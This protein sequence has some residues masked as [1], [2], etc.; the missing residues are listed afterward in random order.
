MP[1]RSEDYR[2]VLS[3]F[4]HIKVPIVKLEMVK[5]AIHVKWIHVAGVGWSGTR[6]K[7]QQW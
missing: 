4:C 5:K 1:L 7:C 6:R 3:T 2:S